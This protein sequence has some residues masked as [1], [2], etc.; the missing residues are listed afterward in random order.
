M[1]CECRDRGELEKAIADARA[2]EREGVVL[3][4]ADGWM[5]K[6]KSDHY[7]RVKSLRPVLKR[8]L[9]GGKPVPMDDS[10]RSRLVR[11]VLG[12][13]DP[14]RLTYRRAEFGEPDVDMTYV[15][16]LID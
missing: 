15:G 16:S 8:V 12:K 14:D 3:Y 13:A 10:E 9:L 7:L 5:V 4:Y 11:T 1:L 6:I 2:G